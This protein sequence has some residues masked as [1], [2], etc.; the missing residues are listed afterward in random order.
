MSAAE[1]IEQIKSLPPAEQ[2]EVAEFVRTY[3]GRAAGDPAVTREEKFQ[4]A[5]D[6]VFNEHRELLHRLAQ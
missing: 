5:E 2:K 4:R 3:E 1:V 6:K